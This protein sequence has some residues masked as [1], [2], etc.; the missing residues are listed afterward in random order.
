LVGFQGHSEVRFDRGFLISWGGIV[1]GWAV[2]SLLSS[3]V[4]PSAWR[5]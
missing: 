4:R 5:N 1:P 3:L 2:F